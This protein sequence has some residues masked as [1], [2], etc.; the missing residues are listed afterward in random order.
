MNS[1]PY[2]Q[3]SALDYIR[4]IQP[5][6][7]DKGWQREDIQVAF[8]AGA[9]APPVARL[10]SLRD[11]ADTLAVS[12]STVNDLVRFGELAYVHAGRGTERKRLTFRPEEIESFIKRHTRRDCHD[13]GPQRARQSGTRKSACDLAIDRSM[14]G[15]NGFLAQRAARLADAKARKRK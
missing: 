5:L 15:S 8:M 6:D 4:T 11:V 9:E 2:T 1:R 12:V 14:A 10:M 7:P 13:P 3:K